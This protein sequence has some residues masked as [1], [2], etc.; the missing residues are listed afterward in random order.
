[1]RDFDRVQ[2][3]QCRQC[4]RTHS[5]VAE[6]STKY[7]SLILESHHSG[8][9]AGVAVE[10]LVSAFRGGRTEDAGFRCG[11]SD[12]DTVSLYS[13]AEIGYGVGGCGCW[14]A[15]VGVDRGHVDDAAIEGSHALEVDA[16][17]STTVRDELEGR[18]SAEISPSVE[19]YTRVV[20]VFESH[21]LAIFSIIS[22]VSAREYLR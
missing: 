20:F 18:Q 14:S 16:V 3:F 15:C 7:V 4:I 13:I 8:C 1:M 12:E 11:Y 22:R 2:L 19:I 17:A 5:A 21:D 9:L 10:S 6:Q